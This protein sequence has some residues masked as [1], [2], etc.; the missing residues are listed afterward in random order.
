MTEQE[1]IKGNTIIG[2]FMGLWN[3]PVVADSVKSLEYSTS[4][5][6]LIPVW[7]KWIQIVSKERMHSHPKKHPNHDK[8][9]AIELNFRQAL[10]ENSTENA[11]QQMVL[12]I[13]LH[14]DV[15]YENQNDS[16]ANSVIAPPDWLT[17][18]YAIELF[19][20]WASSPIT[21]SERL[22]AV[23]YQYQRNVWD[24][25]IPLGKIRIV[26]NG[27]LS[28]YLTVFMVVDVKQMQSGEFTFDIDLETF[29]ILKD[30]Y[31]NSI[32]N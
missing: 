2:K 7:S 17:K 23:N 15:A 4:W 22:H 9:Y 25:N 28:C 21:A 29:L 24:I 11:Y 19:R 20:K 32:A 8:I 5:N 10:F 16:S 13:S 6:S 3:E 27:N 30:I 14:N 12:A 18:E 1:I 26:N 31:F